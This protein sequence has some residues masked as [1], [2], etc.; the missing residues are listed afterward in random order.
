[1]SGMTSYLQKKLL[2]HLTGVASYTF[3]STLYL[4]L[5]TDDPT[6]SGSHS[7]E[8]ST[9]G[10]GYAR[11]SLAGLIG[12]ADAS[13]GRAQNSASIT[14]GSPSA[15]W[16]T[17]THLGIE[18]ASSAGNMLFWVEGSAARNVGVGQLLRLLAG[19]LNIRLN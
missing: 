1:M 11:V 19:Q 5:H 12:A 14:F 8:V 16:G 3:P 9:S 7:N 6:E 17:I 2:D 15:S 13:S 4:S 18:D 10:T